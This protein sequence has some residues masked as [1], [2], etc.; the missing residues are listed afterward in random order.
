MNRAVVE[1]P[2]SRIPQLV[3]IYAPRKTIHATLEIVD[4][5]GLSPGSTANQGRG[6]KLL[7]HV[8]DVDALLHVVNCFSDSSSDPERDMETIDIELIVADVQTLENKISRLEKKAKGCKETAQELDDCRIV[9][10]NLE[11]GI[12][13]RNQKLTDKQE[14]SLRECHLLS[15]KP[16]LY[17]ANIASISDVESNSVKKI[18]FKSNA[19]KSGMIPV[20]G[21]DEAE[22]SQLKEEDRQEFLEVLGLKE[23]SMERLIRAAYQMLGLLSFFT[24]GE[25]EVH[26][27][28][29]YRGD[30]APR[31]AS[32]I[33][34][35]MENG[36]IRMEAISY[37][38]LIKYGSES[39]A[40][41]AGKLRVEGKNYEV[42]DGDIVVIRFSPPH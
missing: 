23:S 10:E 16:V 18:Q 33:H 29:C 32:R 20:C 17:I 8:K 28:T 19:E 31:A 39:A 9:K 22:I 15:Q 36:F 2:D 30:R 24:A 35:D 34:T 42:Q 13:V 5:P 12:S 40:A 26:A 6:S 14:S 41:R 27:W 38:D 7:G 25:K 1:V 11:E 4:I 21:L 37:Q 3:K